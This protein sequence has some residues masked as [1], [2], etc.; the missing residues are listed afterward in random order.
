MVIAADWRNDSSYDAAYTEA[1]F[2]RP[3]V[4]R[5][6][7]GREKYRKG[8]IWSHARSWWYGDRY[9]L[10][11]TQGALHLGRKT[12]STRNVDVILAS[13][14]PAST[15][16]VGALLSAQHGIPLVADL[17]DI[18]NQLPPQ[19]PLQRITILRQV[20]WEKKYLKGS[21]L[22]VSVNGG[23]L[24]ARLRQRHSRP[25]VEISNG[26]DP[27]YFYPATGVEAQSCFTVVYTGSLGRGMNLTVIAEALEALLCEKMVDPGRIRLKFYGSRPEHVRSSFSQDLVWPLV[28]VMP[29]TSAE[30][31]ARAQREATIL[32]H[33]TNPKVKGWMTG[34]AMEYLGARRPVLSVPGDPDSVDRLLAGTG[35]GWP[36]ADVGEAKVLLLDLYRQWQAAG[37]FL[38]FKGKEAEI[39]RYCYP[40]L[41]GRL[42]EHL[43]RLVAGN[44][45]SALRPFS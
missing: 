33:A 44:Q 20:W 8:N 5:V 43:D 10:S 21:S 22:I 13:A 41:A 28:D 7:P 4:G 9:P 45:K 39:R 31:V 35:A 15:L 34:K 24:L 2:E 29:W 18:A 3:V 1:A 36:C 6:D 12:L 30:Q 16:R 42:A 26:Y 40:E 23:R 27:D 14:P 25:I 17:R 11:W 32:L 19:H 38:T 37:G